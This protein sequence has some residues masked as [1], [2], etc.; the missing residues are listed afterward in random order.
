M[1]LTTLKRKSYAF[2]KGT[3]TEDTK[4]RKRFKKSE[5]KN[6]RLKSDLSES[7]QTCKYQRQRIKELT[8]SRDSWKG[9]SKDKSVKIKGLQRRLDRKEHAKGHHYDLGLVQLCVLL[10]I[11]GHC[12]YRS[13]QKILQVLCLCSFLK[14]SRCPCA[15]TIQ[16]WVSKMG[17]YEQE[18]LES[19]LVSEDV[20]LIIDESI[21]IGQQKQLLILSTPFE[22]RHR[23]ALCYEDVDVLYFGGRKSWTAVQINEVLEDLRAKH[24]FN[25]RAI[26]SD[27]DSKLRKLSRLQG[28][29]HL[30]DI[31]HA[32]GTCL[33]KTFEKD[34]EF[35]A[36]MKDLSGYK[37]KG[38][39]QDLTYL[40]PPNQRV[41]ARF[42]NISA[43]LKWA[44][45]MLERFENLSVKER[46]FFKTL[47]THRHLI[48]RLSN[49]I[50]L[51]DRVS[52]SLKM[53]GLS[54]EQVVEMKTHLG[55]CKHHAT[56]QKQEKVLLFIGYMEEY[57][58][59]YEEFMKDLEEVSIP[60]SSEVIESLFGTY[61]NLASSDKL[62]GTTELNLEIGVR[63]MQ[64][65]QIHLKAKEALE[66]ILMTDLKQWKINHSSE[67]QAVRRR[68][69]F[70]NRK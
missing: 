5:G 58:A 54:L 63:C 6:T 42:M 36:F 23:G 28:L 51:A 20:V 39:N 8:A 47:P 35:E 4:I 48:E 68:K 64:K 21:R 9:K 14:L 38:V 61:K 2:T 13:V 59:H 24:G 60:V 52:Y 44:Q 10:R 53:N 66:G 65:D 17:L 26:L 19:E 7:R 30:P 27:E 15:N 3:R 67:N 12:S 32:V 57:A 37:S 70:K 29:K 11:V 25:L 69:F 16:N 31:A 40:L 62:V 49:C 33:R 50:T 46:E 41:K 43:S 18:I 1:N 45:K 34:V 56:V 22:R 55:Q